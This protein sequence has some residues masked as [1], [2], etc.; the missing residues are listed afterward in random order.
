MNLLNQ[1]H[2]NIKFTIEIE[3]GEILNLLDLKIMKGNEELKF[4]IF[5]NKTQTDTTIN[6]TSNHPTRYKLNNL[7]STSKIFGYIEL[8]CHV[9]QKCRK[10]ETKINEYIS[11][12]GTDTF[13]RHLKESKHDFDK[14]KNSKVLDQKNKGT[15]LTLFKFP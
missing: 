2:K 15:K 12:P 1:Q 6:I 8:E 13:G 10:L 5:H 3:E 4:G 9:K 7:I 11:K 14:K